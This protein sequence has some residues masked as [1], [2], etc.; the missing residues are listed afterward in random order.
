[1]S[2]LN[3]DINLVSDIVFTS[4]TTAS[5]Y[6]PESNQGGLNAVPAFF[7][8]K[9]LFFSMPSH[10]MSDFPVPQT[11]LVTCGLPYANGP[12]HVGHLRTYI[13]ADIFVRYLRKLGQEVVF[14]CGSDTHGTPIVVNAE[15]QGITPQELVE[16]YHNHFKQVFSDMEIDFDGYGSTDDPENH[17]RTRSIVSEWMDR[18]MVYQKTLKMAYCRKCGRTLPDRFVVGTCPHCGAEAR[19]DE[20]DQGCGRYLEPGEIMKPRCNVCGTPAQL[21]EQMHYFLKLSKCQGFLQDFLKDLH[22]TDNALN[23]A[24]EWAGGELRDWCITRNLDWGVRFPADESLVVYVWVDAPIGYISFTEQW[25]GRTGGTWEAIWRGDGRIIHFIGLDITYH[26]CILWPAMLNA[27]GYN[28]PWSVVASGM[29]KINGNKLSKSRGNVIW[30]NEDYLDRG[31]H[32][33]LLRYY[34]ATYTGHTREIDFSWGAFAEKVNNELVA[35]LGNFAYRVLHFTHNRAGGIPDAAP[36][37][38][39]LER[40]KPAVKSVGGYLSR[41]EFKEICDT[42]MELATWGN[43]M[44]QQCEPWKLLDSDRKACEQVLADGV[45]LS[46]ALAVLLSPVM[47]GKM[48][49]LWAQLGQRGSVHDALL[50]QSFAPLEPG[51]EAA[52]PKPLFEKMDE[53][54]TSELVSRLNVR[55]E[56]ANGRM[57]APKGREKDEGKEDKKVES[58]K[59]EKSGDEPVSIDDFKRLHIVMGRILSA[60]KIEGSDLLYKLEVDTGEARPRQIVAGMAVTH[61]PEDMVGRTVPVLVNLKPAKLRGVESH[62]MILAAGDKEAVLLLPEKDVPPGTRV[63]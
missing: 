14:V 56:S 54:F 55:V 19:G 53:G 47:P 48:E 27:A 45:Q 50:D 11:V 17:E 52:P 38:R 24:R 31:L 34:I 2:R 1:M 44:F 57:K 29:M 40:I 30:A 60:E 36:S 13:P 51:G 26:H 43:A 6:Y 37:K 35:T 39:V 33:D 4:R 63:N 58:K 46:K 23:F 59:P 10:P 15:E 5:G 49:E 28:L 32:P 7:A 20:C 22:G 3:A 18:D 62:G 42:V 25:A 16:R 12:C 61:K 9:V 21:T 41:Y 8:D